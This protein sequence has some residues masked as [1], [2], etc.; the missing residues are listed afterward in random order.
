MNHFNINTFTLLASLNF[1]FTSMSGSILQAPQII[2][3]EAVATLTENFKCHM[4]FTGESQTSGTEFFI[5]FI[6]QAQQ[7][8]VRIQIIHHWPEE[9]NNELKTQ[10]QEINANNTTY[11]IWESKPFTTSVQ[12]TEYNNAQTET[13]HADLKQLQ[14]FANWIK[15]KKIAFYTGAGISAPAIPPLTSLMKALGIEA[16]NWLWNE[17]I[18]QIVSN[19]QPFLE[20]MH[21]F[22]ISCAHSQP[23]Q[24]HFAIK[25]ICE[26][27]NWAL[28]T[29]NL[30]LLHQKT[31]IRPIARE[32]GNPELENQI[33]DEELKKLD[34]LV[35]VGQS[36]DN[37]GILQ[38]YHKANPHGSIV[39]FNLS[40]ELY[41]NQGDEQLSIG[42][43]EGDV[44]VTLPLLLG[45]LKA[46]QE[47]T[48]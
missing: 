38:R 22:F 41:G 3:K 34:C 19:P 28:V 36:T 46:Q 15:N 13:E 35:V 44:Q 20:I 21:P 31:G 1:L 12:L 45:Y 9:L 6:H 32:N 8:T 10:F 33:K 17:T 14:E 24:A 26:L 39:S 42:W 37:S 18:Y 23:T 43:I 25:E 7:T 30:D 11:W 5:F 2:S 4:A 48:Q 27:K 47:I 16:G 40:P 29:E